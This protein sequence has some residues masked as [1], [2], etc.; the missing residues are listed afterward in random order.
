M[1]SI[2]G[3]KKKDVSGEKPT[4]TRNM[5]NTPEMTPDEMAV[6]QDWDEEQSRLLRE[7]GGVAYVHG[8][9]LARSIA[10]EIV[11]N[12]ENEQGNQDVSEIMHR[13]AVEDLWPRLH[14]RN[15][16]QNHISNM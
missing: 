10:E 9:E 7:L 11:T 8:V 3:I 5:T 6:Y 15:A 2:W 13:A 14:E 4:T 12:Q 16:S 1:N